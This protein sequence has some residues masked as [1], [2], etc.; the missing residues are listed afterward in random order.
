M[1][2]CHAHLLPNIDDGSKSIE[3]SIKVLRQ[4]A[5]GGIKS[6]IC[7]S[8][9]MK[10]HFQYKYEDYTA[11]FRE[12]EEEIKTQNI[13]IKIYTGAEVFL[14][15]GISKDIKEQKLTLAD[16]SY[17]LVET[18]LN[19]FPHDFYKNIYDLIKF[20]YKPVLAH[21]ERYVSIMMKT[22]SIKELIKRGIYVQINSASLI[23][24]YG[25]KVKHTAWKMMNKGWVHLLGSDEHIKGDYTS[26]FKARDKI[27]EHVDEATARLLTQ[28]YPQAILTDE[29]IPLDYVIVH[30]EN[31]RK[32]LDILF[33]SKGNR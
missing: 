17:V 3:D 14:T 10:S 13:P 18:D 4:M 21:G 2:D 7:T 27:V 26:F 5:A 23:G 1:I 8:H 30:K 28:T 19:G 24:G 25:E 16:S 22:H 33:H 6:V 15:P 12:L 11:R 9:Y 20:G 32:F 29:K 31:R